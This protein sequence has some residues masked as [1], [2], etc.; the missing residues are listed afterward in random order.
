[1]R[2]LVLGAGSTGGYFGARLHEAGGEVTFL[3]RPRRKAFLQQHGLHV[4]SPLGNVDFA[5]RLV[6]REELHETFDLVLL[7][8]K[9]YDLE[10][11][12]DDVA[13]AVGAGT[14]ILPLLNGMRH[15]QALDARFGRAHVAGGVVHGAMRITAA[16]GI[17]H[18]NAFHRL[19]TGGRGGEPGAPVRH[20]A[21]LIELQELMRHSNVEYRLFDTIE[22]TMWN[23]FVFWS[24]L[25]GATCTLRADVCDV[26][27]TAC[28]GEFMFGLLDECAAVSAASGHPLT[29]SQ[30]ATS[31]AMM[32]E[33]GSRLHASM[34][35]DLER[36]SRTE[37]EHTLGD[38]VRRAADGG[39]A[40]PRLLL[41]Y[42]HM[43]AYELRR[44]AGLLPC[45]AGG[46]A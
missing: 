26:M 32:S 22:Q 39:I 18:F 7:S 24:A 37:N 20:P 36:G 13:P 21:P 16:G 1:M 14:V 34:R 2:I 45:Q 11:A 35:A 28:G 38:L 29:E 23:K 40:I 4:T 44:Q 6:T 46:A 8:C 3:V 42:S 17:E 43:Q 30:L 9:A 41:A 15:L 5:P 31:R 25:A 12:M 19:M 33:P 10:S 27:R